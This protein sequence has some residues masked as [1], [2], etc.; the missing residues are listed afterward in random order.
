MIERD[1]I[2]RM[3]RML[4]AALSRILLHRN[5][6][7]YEE[8]EKEIDDA[9]RSLTGMEWQTLCAFSDR[10][11]ASLL[12]FPGHRERLIAVAELLRTESEMLLEQGKRDEGMAIGR[13]AFG[14]FALLVTEEEQYLSM[15]QSDKFR[16]LLEKF[17]HDDDLPAHWDRACALLREWMSDHRSDT[18]PDLDDR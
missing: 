14:V 18:I 9:S 2:L 16:C 10:Q 1:Y 4:T 6:G 5:L 8:A 3:I 15:L 11:L 13:K 7:Q 12:G 17:T